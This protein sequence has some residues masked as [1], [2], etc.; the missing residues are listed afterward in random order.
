MSASQNKHH[1]SARITEYKMPPIKDALVLGRD[2]PIG[3][4][5]MR[6]ALSLLIKSPYEHIELEDE[7]ISDILVRQSLLRRLSREQLIQFVLRNIKPLM[8]EDEVLHLDI[9]VEVVVEASGE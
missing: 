5:A 3:C 7:V 1:L 6:R 4:H 2:T 9:E 8:A